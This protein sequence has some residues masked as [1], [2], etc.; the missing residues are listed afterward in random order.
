[1]AVNSRWLNDVLATNRNPLIV[2]APLGVDLYG[3]RYNIN[4]DWPPHPLAAALK[5]DEMIFLNRYGRRLDEEGKDSL[6]LDQGLRN[7]IDAK[8]VTGG[9]MTKCL[10]VIFALENGVGRVRILKGDD[11]ARAK[12]ATELGTTCIAASVEYKESNDA[13]V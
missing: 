12:I 4:A 5:V 2:L 8:T 7:M 11:A 1:M 3:R 9:M 13:F 6:R 10:A